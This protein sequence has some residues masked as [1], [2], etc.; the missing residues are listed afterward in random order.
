[1][2]FWVESRVVDGGG[3]APADIMRVQ[4]R[5]MQAIN[6]A[7]GSMRELGLTPFASTGLSKA[8]VRPGDT[9]TGGV[10]VLS[11]ARTTLR[12]T[13]TRGDGPVVFEGTAGTCTGAL[14]K[15]R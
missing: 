12:T 3:L 8:P 6:L 9:I 10:D 13:V 2:T 11:C 15:G 1:M 5:R 14:G 4:R 7:K